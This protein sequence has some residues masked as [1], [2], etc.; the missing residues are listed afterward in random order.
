MLSRPE[1][2]PQLV[3][4]HSRHIAHVAVGGEMEPVL[5]LFGMESFELVHS[6]P[7]LINL[8]FLSGA[9]GGQQQ[10]KQQN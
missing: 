7:N 5:E 2:L 6:H 3:S 4:N 10:A 9:E 1:L 8:N